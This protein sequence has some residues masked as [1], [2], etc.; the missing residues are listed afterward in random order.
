MAARYSPHTALSGRTPIAAWHPLFPAKNKQ[1]E[2][3]EIHVCVKSVSKQVSDRQEQLKQR[4]KPAANRR[5]DNSL[6]LAGGAD[7]DTLRQAS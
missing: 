5:H 4:S 2:G 6:V 3:E 1:G 7:I